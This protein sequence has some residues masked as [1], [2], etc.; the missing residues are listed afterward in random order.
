[1]AIELHERV[2]VVGS[3]HTRFMRLTL[4]KRTM[5]VNAEVN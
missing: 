1:M 4:D 3:H 5:L 2:Q